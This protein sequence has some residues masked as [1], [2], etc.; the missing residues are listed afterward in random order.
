VRRATTDKSII[1]ALLFASQ[2]FISGC[3]AGG[4][5][6]LCARERWARQWSAGPDDSAGA[7]GQRATLA[8]DRLRGAAAV[9][10]AGIH[11]LV[12][13]R[14]SAFAWPD[15]H[16]Y[17]TTGLLALLDDD[18]LT[19]AVAHELGHLQACDHQVASLRGPAA[20]DV[21]ARADALGCEIMKA[22]G[23]SPRVLARAL[24]KVRDAYDTPAQCRDALT[25][26]IEWL[27]D[28]DG[29]R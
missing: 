19:A 29:V 27:H 7:A 28:S 25:R 23:Y 18:E 10:A 26:R 21:E 13:R 6:P 5:P 2:I 15:R 16:V 9:Q 8:L 22:Q 4:K 20:D 17:V 11:V 14:P 1:L 12:C 24:S 3:A